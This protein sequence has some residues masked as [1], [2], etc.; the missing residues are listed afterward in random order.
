MLGKRLGKAMK[1]VGEAVKALSRE[2]IAAFE[3]DGR[4]SVQGHELEVG[5]LKVR[6]GPSQNSN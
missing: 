2:Q 4:L 5:D 1:S 6:N 3:R